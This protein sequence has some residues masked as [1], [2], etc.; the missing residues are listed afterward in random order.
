M[1]FPQGKPQALPAVPTPVPTVPTT[2]RVV[3]PTLPTANASNFAPPSKKP[4][5]FGRNTT[6]PMPVVP[7]RVDSAPNPRPLMILPPLS[8]APLSPLQ[9]PYFRDTRSQPSTP[10]SKSTQTPK[11]GLFANL[12]SLLPSSWSSRSQREQ[13][14]FPSPLASPQA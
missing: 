6:T 14:L 7:S 12:A 1:T 8:S 5:S 2:A 3:V 10:T 9:R 11:S 13:P 4:F